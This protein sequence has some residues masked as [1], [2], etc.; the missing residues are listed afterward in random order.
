M[1]L[2]F[3]HNLSR[4][5]K[6]HL[7]PHE[8][9]LT[10]EAGWDDFDNGELLEAAQQTF[11]ALLTT[12]TNI[13]HQQKVEQ[14]DIAVIVLRAYNNKYESLRPMMP[15]VLSLLETVEPGKVY[16][17][18]IDEKLKESDRRKGKGPVAD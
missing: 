5:L 14:F 18:Y 17:V 12:D 2:L 7:S 13:Y 10:R 9:V 1:R 11:D 16:H 3:D 4:K 8:V 15:D 6:N